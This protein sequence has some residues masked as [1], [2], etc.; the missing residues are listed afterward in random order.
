METKRKVCPK[1]KKVFT[2]TDE[3]TYWDENSSYGSTKLVKCSLCG[4]PI[5]LK[6][7]YD[8]SN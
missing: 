8:P 4:N 7:T 3:E 5:V 1:C 2:Y 6:V